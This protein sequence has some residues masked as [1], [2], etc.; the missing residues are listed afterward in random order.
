M[1]GVL[2]ENASLHNVLSVQVLRRMDDASYNGYLHNPL[3]PTKKKRSSSIVYSL[4]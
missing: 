3:P 4:A 1:L 2:G